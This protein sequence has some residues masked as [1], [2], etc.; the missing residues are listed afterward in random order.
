MP[1]KI[2]ES[3]YPEDLFQAVGACM[4]GPAR[5]WLV[6]HTKARHE[7]ALAR[8]LLRLRIPFYLPLVPKIWLKRRRICFQ[9][10]LFDGYLFLFGSENER[11]RCLATNRVVRVLPV[12]DQEMLRSDLR[13]LQELIATGVPLTSGWS[14][15]RSIPVRSMSP[16]SVEGTAHRR[17][18]EPRVVVSLD[19]DKGRLAMQFAED[20]GC[21]PAVAQDR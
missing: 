10:P 14:N 21:G 15:T 1:N 12:F 20:G 5:Q 11:V 17:K 3:I 8:E 19:L 6:V 4:N 7:K 13:R 9:V 18:A 2:A 16:S